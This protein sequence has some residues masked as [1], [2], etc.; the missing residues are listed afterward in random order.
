MALLIALGGCK[1]NCNQLRCS[2]HTG[3]NFEKDCIIVWA[4]Q[5]TCRFTNRHLD[6]LYNVLFYEGIMKT[7]FKVCAFFHCSFKIVITRL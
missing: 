7:H 1:S 5:N 4:H 2:G 6:F 3:Q